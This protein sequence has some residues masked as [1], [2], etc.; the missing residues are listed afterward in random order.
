[1]HPGHPEVIEENIRIG[2]ERSGKTLDGFDI[3]PVVAVVMGDDLDMCRAPLKMQLALYIGG[4]GARDKNF[5]KD[6]ICRVGF[7]EAAHVIQDLYLDGRKGE[8]IAAVP[9]ELVDAL[10][11]VGPPDRIRDHF[12]KWKDARIG[13][14]CLGTLQVEAIRL[15]AELAL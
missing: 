9:D 6:Y 7:E 8:A 11:L 1:M 5:Y 14:L 12:Q 2:R 3:A 15:I 10:Y 13:T 4:M